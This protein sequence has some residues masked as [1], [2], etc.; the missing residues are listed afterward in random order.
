MRAVRGASEASRPRGLTTM[1]DLF[2]LASRTH[3]LRL[4]TT[5]EVVT[6]PSF[7]PPSF[8]PFFIALDILPTTTPHTYNNVVV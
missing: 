1:F 3:L 2:N 8:N 7:S 4:Q 5:H 6:S